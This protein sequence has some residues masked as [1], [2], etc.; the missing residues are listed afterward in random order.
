[1]KAALDCVFTE[2]RKRIPSADTVLK[3]SDCE[4]QERAVFVTAQ[5]TTEVQ[6]VFASVQRGTFF[7]SLPFA[8]GSALIMFCA[9]TV[10]LCIPDR[11]GEISAL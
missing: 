8:K 4:P 10:D 1:M 5:Q 7:F 11:A 2:P 3:D 9:A 6:S